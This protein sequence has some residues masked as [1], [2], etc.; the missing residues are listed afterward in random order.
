MTQERSSSTSSR[1]TSEATHS[2]FFDHVAD[3]V[4]WT[5]IGKNPFSGEYLSK[6]EFLQATYERLTI[7]L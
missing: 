6:R 5:V 3:D 1:P 7:V 4:H 2:K